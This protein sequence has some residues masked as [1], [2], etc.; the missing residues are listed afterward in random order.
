MKLTI[1]PTIIFR[2]PKFSYQSELVDCWEALK[3]AISI[4][5][6]TFYETIKEVKANELHDLPPKVYFTIWKYFNRAKFRST[7]YGTFAGFSLLNDAIKPS[8]SRIVI[9]EDQKIRELIDWPYKNNIQLRLQDLLQ[10]NCLLFSNSSYYLTTD[11]IRYIACTDGVFELAELDQNEF[12]QQIL[13]ACLKPIRL[14]DLLSQLSLTDTET[15]NFFGLLQDMHDLQLD[16]KSV[17]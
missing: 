11:S 5:S 2:T 4:S 17:V 9:D 1:Q 12:V 6:A 8:E 7:P 10:K 3:S 15:Q 16:R 14:N 13:A